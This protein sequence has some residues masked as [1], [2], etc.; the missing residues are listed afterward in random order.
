[1][2]PL[3]WSFR[4]QFAAG[5]AVCAALLVYA[6]YVQYQLGIEP[7]PLCTFQRVAFIAMGVLFL[8][9]ALHN[10]RTWGRGVYALLVVLAGCAGIALAARHVWIQ[11]LPADQIPDCGPGLSYMLD[12]FPLAKTLK[13]V[14]TGSGEC[15]EVN[16]TFLGVSM[17]GWTLVCF[18]ALS[19]GAAWAAFA[20]RR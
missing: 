4:A 11:H 3:R 15:A 1:M 2:N 8:L 6:L 18:A 5:F 13:L 9:G 12:T 17:P 14:L 16:W 19:A 20:R 7:C 10:P